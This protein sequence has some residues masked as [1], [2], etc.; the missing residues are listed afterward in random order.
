[1]KK[2]RIIVLILSVLLSS[3][4]IAQSKKEQDRQAIKKMCGCY[5]VGFNFAETFHYSKDSTYQPSEIKHANALEWVELVEDSENKL[6]LQHL[7]IVGKS[8]KPHIV[9]HWRQ[10]WIF[11]NRELYIYQV[12]NH[13]KYIQLPDNQVKGTWTQKVYQVDDSPRYEGVASWIHVDG[14]SFWENTTDA[15]LPRREYTKR[16]D[17]NVTERGNRHEITAQGWI[18]DQD[19]KKIIRQ[20]N[21][22]DIILAEEKGFN[23][24]KKVEDSQCQAAQNWWKIHAQ[25]WI[26]VRQ[27][28]DN[29]FAQKQDLQLHQAV[30]GKPLF[31]HLF[32][33]K[34]N[35]KE[36]DQIIDSFLI[37]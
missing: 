8:D 27:K 25:T 26:K 14:K 37:Q 3:N 33:D 34:L 1:M 31:K 10:D 7:L 12:D 13:W 20:K 2:N 11:E 28:W 19:N 24:Y 15:P 6:I 29:V 23:T 4:L 30:E 18:H 21:K 16:S 35:I 36:I 9:K 17:Y 32:D 5:E 22:L